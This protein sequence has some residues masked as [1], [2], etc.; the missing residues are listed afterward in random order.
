[1]PNV[2]YDNVKCRM[3]PRDLR[4]RYQSVGELLMEAAEERE[5]NEGYA[6]R[7]AG[8]DG[9]LSR[10][11]DFVTSERSCCPFLRFELTVE[12]DRGPIWLRLT[13]PE[14]VKR[15]VQD[16]LTQARPIK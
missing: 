4:R 9:S 11:A 16:A 1:M 3:E 15:V 12:P 10:L 8:D 2:D 5:L 13:G 14:P 6:F 7:F